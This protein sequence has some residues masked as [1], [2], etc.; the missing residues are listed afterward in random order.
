MEQ[1]Q[2]IWEMTRDWDSNWE[3][4][5][6]GKFGELETKTM[7]ETANGMYKKL[8]KMSRELKVNTRVFE[9]VFYNLIMYLTL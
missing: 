9:H 3:I 6:S 5:K 7:E 1:I 2:I 4:W 8:H